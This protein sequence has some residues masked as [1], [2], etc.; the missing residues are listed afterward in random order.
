MNTIRAPVA[1]HAA[2]KLLMALGQTSRQRT[3]E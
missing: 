3:P 2:T 1:L